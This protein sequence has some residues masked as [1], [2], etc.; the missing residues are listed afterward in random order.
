M[1]TL[2]FKDMLLVQYKALYDPEEQHK[3]GVLIYI[4]KKR[5][6]HDVDIINHWNMRAR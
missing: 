5:K 2:I 1:P 3:N 6:L 4:L